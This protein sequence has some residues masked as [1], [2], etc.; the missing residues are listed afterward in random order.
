MLGTEQWPE[1]RRRL[2]NRQ[3]WDQIFTLGYSMEATLS[4]LFNSLSFHFLIY[5]QTRLTECLWGSNE[6]GFVRALSVVP[7]GWINRKPA[8]H[9]HL[10]SYSSGTSGL[11]SGWD[12]ESQ[13][14]SKIIRISL[15][16]NWM[17][18]ISIIYC[19]SNAVSQRETSVAFNSNVYSCSWVQGL[20]QQLC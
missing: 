6:V 9:I 16:G 10:P 17:K 5:K 18:E 4:K 2:C 12:A 1:V 11:I 8:K 7:E 14:L 15:E 20:A 19:H 13:F 3:S